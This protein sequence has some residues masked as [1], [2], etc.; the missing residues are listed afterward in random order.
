MLLPGHSS[1][2]TVLV[3]YLWLKPQAAGY[4]FLVAVPVSHVGDGGH[5][6]SRPA[7]LMLLHEI[8]V[9]SIVS[10]V[11]LHRSCRI[12]FSATG[13]RRISIIDTS[14]TDGPTTPVSTVV[15]WQVESGIPVRVNVK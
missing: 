3:C 1:A 8:C 5:F 4:F 9:I 14:V 13:R 12:F 6:G 2:C 15:S 11:S 10:C 7:S